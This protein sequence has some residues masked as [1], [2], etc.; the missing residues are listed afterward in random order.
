MIP[1][2][3]HYCWFGRGEMPKLMKK[4]IRTWKKYCPDWE[5]ICWDEDRFD[6]NSTVFTAQAYQ[7]RKFAFVADYVRL[8][9]LYEMG[10]VYLDADQELLKPLEPFLHHKA[11]VGFLNTNE[12]SA[13]V[14]GAEPGHPVIG[15]M[16][17]LY[18]D[19]RFSSQDGIDLT[20]NTVGMTDLLKQHGLV[21]D[22]SYQEIREMA[23]YPQTYFCP[24][25]C[26]T[27]EH[28]I[29]KD[30]VSIHLWAGSWHSEKGRRDMKRAKF[31]TSRWYRGWIWLRYLPSR[32]L[33]SIFGDAAIDKLRNR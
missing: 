32:I 15:E 11:F 33:R 30:T 5:I 13:G 29:S 23:V 22:D 20:P 14:V 10:G 17:G 21:I 31:H 1:K 6:I 27:V 4:C 12:I 25:S 28:C 7:A 3:I 26:I 19:K 8:K 9:V 18:E 16:L 24:T 2:I